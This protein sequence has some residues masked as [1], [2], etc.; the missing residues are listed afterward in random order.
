[1]HRVWYANTEFL[2]DDRIAEALME[3]A[4]V[5][6]VVN[7]S[8]V[9]QL[10]A[11]DSD[12]VRRDVRMVV[13]PASQILAMSADDTDVEMAVDETVEELERRS[14]ERLPQSV[15]FVAARA[16]GA[17]EGGDPEAP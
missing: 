15:D 6:A 10:P 11:I 12:G 8:D 13:G 1:M 9:V 5:L 14:R 2:T 17:L 4:S 7:S 3:Y 16:A